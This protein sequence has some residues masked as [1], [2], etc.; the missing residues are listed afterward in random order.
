MKSL[1]TL[2]LFSGAGGL[3]LGFHKAGFHTV[4]AIDNNAPALETFSKNFIGSKTYNIDLSD[5]NN[6]AFTE[7]Q[8]IDVMLGGPPCQGFSIAGKRDIN[9]P[10]NT[11]FISYLKLVEKYSPKAVVIENVPN[12]LSMNKGDFANQIVT[13]LNQLGYDVCVLKLNAAEFGVPQSRKRAFFIGLKE[14]MF[15]IHE[16]E[17]LKVSSPITTGDALSDLPLLEEHLGSEVEEYLCLPINN[18]QSLMRS[19]SNKIYNH[20]AVDHKEQTKNIIA[21]VPDGGN[22]KDLPE[23]LHLTRKVNI[24][25]TRMNSRKPCFT[26]DAGHNHHFHYKANRVPTVRECARIQSFP[27]DFIFVGNRTSQYR[28]VG[29]A[30]PPLLAQKIAEILYKL[31]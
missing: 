7:I 22:Y 10:R 29:N 15:P 28:Q 31:L 26:I 18:Y 6:P 17:A 16:L 23:E 9:D 13:G 14:G 19:N 2:D 1:R 12:I 27:D 11:L 20:Q 21:L 24:A 8:N 25:W 30:V 3:S 5:I 4:A